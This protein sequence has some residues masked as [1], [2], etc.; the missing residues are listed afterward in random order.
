M[1]VTFVV[2]ELF[3]FER[4]FDFVLALFG[5]VSSF[6][7]DPF[8]LGFDFERDVISMKV[9]ER[10]HCRG[11]ECRIVS[12]LPCGIQDELLNYISRIALCAVQIHWRKRVGFHHRT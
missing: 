10:A 3:D 9:Q 11:R 7:D 5:A 6:L 12:R 4:G 2:L 8:D 1:V